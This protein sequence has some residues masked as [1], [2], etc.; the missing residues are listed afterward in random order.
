MFGSRSLGGNLGIRIT[1]Y[2]FVC[3]EINHD[4]AANHKPG[5]CFVTIL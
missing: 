4:F 5:H 1:Y 2:K 3:P